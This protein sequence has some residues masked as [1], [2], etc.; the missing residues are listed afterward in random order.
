VAEFLSKVIENH[1]A[2]YT[3]IEK[4]EEVY[5]VYM[6]HNVFQSEDGVESK[7]EKKKVSYH[8]IY[9]PDYWKVSYPSSPDD[10]EGMAEMAE[11]EQC[12]NESRMMPL[13]DFLRK[14]IQI[15]EIYDRKEV[16][17]DAY[18]AVIESYLSKLRDW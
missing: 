17:K 15:F 16:D 13:N 2:S 12:G 6:T 9:F 14:F 3:T 4:E 7:V 11:A 10:V 1:D 8:A 5:G 18:R